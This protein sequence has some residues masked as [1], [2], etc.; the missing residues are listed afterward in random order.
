MDS[1]SIKYGDEILLSDA[2][3]QV[4]KPLDVIFFIY[5]LNF[6]YFYL[7]L[8]VQ[9]VLEELVMLYLQMLEIEV[10]FGLLHI[11]VHI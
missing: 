2:N 4:N 3:G 10:V 11:Q 9:H 5:R 1:Q 6:S 8:K 7:V